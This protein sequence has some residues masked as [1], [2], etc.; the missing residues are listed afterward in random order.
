MPNEKMNHVA[1]CH[2]CKTL[3]SRE[4]TRTDEPIELIYNYFALCVHCNAVLTLAFVDSSIFE[5]YPPMIKAESSCESCNEKSLWD[6]RKKELTGSY[7]PRLCITDQSNTRR[8]HYICPVTNA[9]V[10]FDTVRLLRYFSYSKVKEMEDNI[11]NGSTEYDPNKTG[12]DIL[13]MRL[14]AKYNITW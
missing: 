11:R 14:K 12:N 4:Y 13:Y 7:H 1:W 6:G 2:Q 3:E 8:S 10:I 9:P 5:I